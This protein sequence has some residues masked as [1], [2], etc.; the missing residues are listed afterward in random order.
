[1]FS[2]LST[3]QF[4]VDSRRAQLL[5]DARAYRLASI[6]RAGRRALRRAADDAVAQM[7]ARGARHDRYSPPTGEGGSST[8]DAAMCAPVGKAG[9]IRR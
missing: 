6:A 4:E 8:A 7:A 5:E 1:M 9:E 3:N 2:N